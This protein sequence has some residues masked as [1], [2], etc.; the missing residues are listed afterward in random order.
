MTIYDQWIKK[1][2]LFCYNITKNYF[3]KLFKKTRYFM[4][5]YYHKCIG[6]DSLLYFNLAKN[7]IK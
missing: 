4:T 7:K 6:T 1:N 3:E 2:T 5:I